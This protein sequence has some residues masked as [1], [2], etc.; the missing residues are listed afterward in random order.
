MGMMRRSRVLLLAAS[1]LGLLACALLLRWQYAVPILVYHAVGHESTLVSR[2]DFDR[3]M[4][5]LRRHHYNVITFAE[6]VEDLRAKRKVPYGT[7]V[8][9]FDD[10][11][12]DNIL[13]VFPVLLK[14]RLPGTIFAPIAFIGTP[15]YLTWEDVRKLDAS[16]LV[17]F[18]S[19]G[20]KHRPLPELQGKELW[21]SLAGSKKVLEEHLHKPVLVY[22]YPFGKVNSAARKQLAE[23]GYRG[24]ATTAISL[25]DPR[26]DFF[27]LGRIGVGRRDANMLYFWIQLSGFNKWFSYLD[28]WFPA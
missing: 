20:W 19:H 8:I 7:V 22:A 4:G 28:E 5:F 26:E 14:Y 12:D 16:G 17:T 10:A 18:G 11:L 1:V 9:T 6:L 27:C 3:Q 15:H 23:A 24:A 2:A 25:F 21:I 13:D